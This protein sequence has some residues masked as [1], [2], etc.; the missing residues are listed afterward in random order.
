ML[1]NLA[2][3]T[4]L[5]AFTAIAQARPAAGDYHAMQ[6]TPKS[7][8]LKDVNLADAP[9]CPNANTDRVVATF[10]DTFVR[11]TDEHVANMTIPALSLIAGA[12]RRAAATLA[13]ESS[14]TQT[15]V[16]GLFRI[17]GG[18]VIA[19]ALDPEGTLHERIALGIVHRDDSGKI[20]CGDVVVGIAFRQDTP[21]SKK[22]TKK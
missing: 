11:V 5:L 16:M 7:A 3:L 15:A 8:S 20:M 10:Q 4:T 1:R 14:Q 9:G 21:K 19:A 12:D 6:D 17:D 13:D 22:V 18:W 2:S